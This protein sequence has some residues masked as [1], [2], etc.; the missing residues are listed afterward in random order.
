[1]SSI[2]PGR[3]HWQATHKTGTGWHL[4]PVNTVAGA[5]QGA[6]ARTEEIVSLQQAEKVIIGM[7]CHTSR[8][9]AQ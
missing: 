3:V 4:A 2:A 7:I 1:M 6:Q 9:A 5:G 8:P